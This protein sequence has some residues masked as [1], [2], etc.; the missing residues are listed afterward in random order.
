VT[1]DT[2]RQFVDALDAAG[3]LVRITRP[4]SLDLELCEIADRVMKQP[5]GGRALLFE[6]PRLMNGQRSEFPVAINIFGSMQRMATSLG[7][8]DLDLLQQRDGLGARLAVVHAAMEAQRLDDLAADGV[9]RRQ[10]GHRLLEDE[11]DPTA[12]DAGRRFRR[13][14]LDIADAGRGGDSRRSKMN[15]L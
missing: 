4:V 8:R 11:P 12:A 15:R 13:R 5:G 6:Q 1:F 14:A 7:V 2:L 10:R 3:D 9:D